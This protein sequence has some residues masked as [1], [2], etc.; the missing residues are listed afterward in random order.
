MIYTDTQHEQRFDGGGNCGEADKEQAAQNLS[1]T[2][3]F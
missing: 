3:T 2:T 1:Y